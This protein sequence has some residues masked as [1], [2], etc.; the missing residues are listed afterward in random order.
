MSNSW[1]GLG[2]IQK[3]VPD[4]ENI[5]DHLFVYDNFPEMDFGGIERNT[6]F[7]I[8]NFNIEE[9]T[10]YAL[11]L[12][13]S[14]P[15]NIRIRFNYDSS[16]Y[17]GE[18]I[19]RLASLYKTICL[20]SFGADTPSKIKN[21]TAEFA[22][23]TENEKAQVSESFKSGGLTDRFSE[24]VAQYADKPAIEM[25]GKTLTFRQADELSNR[26]AWQLHT[27]GGLLAGERIAID[28]TPSIEAVISMI[29]IVKLGCC[30]I[31]FD[32]LMPEKRLENIIKD[33]SPAVILV[34][35]DKEP[36]FSIK[37]IK[38]SLERL[39]NISV[40]SDAIFKAERNSESIANIMFTSGTTSKPKGVIIKDGGILG[41]NVEP[42]YIDFEKTTCQFQDSSIAFDAAT[43]EIWS[44]MLNGRKLVVI[45]RNTLLSTEMFAKKISENKG[46][47]IF[48]TTTLFNNFVAQNAEIFKDASYVITG[49]EK[50]SE[51]HGKKFLD[52]C[53]DTKL[54]N[55]YGPTE[56]TTLTTCFEVIPESL[57]GT[58]PIGK[59]INTRGVIICDN[60]GD[61]LPDG[62][63]GEIIIYGQ[64]LALGYCGDKEITASKFV[65]L[66][67]GTTVYKSGDY[68]YRDNTGNIYFC[69]RFDNQLKLRGFR[70]STDEIEAALCDCSDIVSAAV[71]A[72]RNSLNGMF[73]AAYVVTKDGVKLKEC[74][75]RITEELGAI[76]PYYMIPSEFIEM[77]SLPV[78]SNGKLDKSMLKE[79][80]LHDE[81]FVYPETETEKKIY[82][83][84]RMVITDKKF[85]MNNSFIKMGGD[86]IK[87]MK[88]TALLKKNGFNIT[89]ADLYREQTP[90]RLAVYADSLSEGGIK[91]VND[92]IP[93]TENRYERFPLNNV[94]VAYL[95][96]RSKELV[97]GGYGTAFFSET[98]G[99]YDCKKFT[100]ALNTVIKRHDML[101]AVIY[102]NGTQQILHP[103]DVSYEIRETDIS[104]MDKAEQEKYL[105]LRYKELR[106]T[107]FEIGKWPMF[108]MRVFRTSENNVH[109]MYAFD[110]LIMDAFS[111][112]MLAGELESVYDGKSDDEELQL[113]FRDYVLESA[114]KTE[115][116][117]KDKKY[118]LDKV[119]N[120]PAA[121]SIKF[122]TLPENLRSP[123]FGRKH[124][125]FGREV[126]NRIK[127]LSAEMNITPAILLCGLYAYSLSL[128]SGQSKLAVNLTVF[129]R[130]QIHRQVDKILGDFTK[131]VLLDYDFADGND[132]KTILFQ[133]HSRLNDY[134]THLHFDGIDFMREL[135]R[136]QKQVNG[137]PLMPV[138][139]T[140]ALF[141]S[142]NVKLAYDF[143]KSASRTP[144]VYLDCQA[145]LRNEELHIV[146]DYPLG[147][148]ED[149]LLDNMF[150]CFT[151][152]ISDVEN[153]LE[154]RF[155]RNM[156]IENFY[157]RYNSTFWKHRE[158]SLQQLVKESLYS[159]E[160]KDKVWLLAENEQFTYEQTRKEAEKYA[161]HLQI[162]GVSCGDF[163]CI[164]GDR[165]P[166][167][168][169]MILGTVL[170]GA[171]Y[172]PVQP[173][174][175]E[176]RKKG[177]AS[178]SHCKC[179][180]KKSIN[181]TS[182][183][184]DYTETAKDAPAYVIYTSG[185]TGNPK[186]VLINQSAVT[187]TIL[188]INERYNI[189]AED[190]FAAV[191]SFSFDLSVY[192]IFGSLN[193]GA[194]ISLI[195]DMKNINAVVSQLSRDRVT[196]WNT[197]PALMELLTE[198][199]DRR[200][201]CGS[202][203]IRIALLSGDWIP[204]QLPN[205]VR[206]CFSGVKV[207][208]L[209]GATEASVWSIAYDIDEN[210]Q[211]D[212]HIPYG[213]PLR[214]QNM[215]VL[216]EA[217]EPLPAGIE[218]YIYRG[219][220]SCRRLSE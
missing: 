93:D 119:E 69:S 39:E 207:V 16:I 118:W 85:G 172:I 82:D 178:L 155:P 215:Y 206:K 63:I 144:Q 219:R 11:T 17:S 9:R 136:V 24:I 55:G 165:E 212:V 80:E 35:G 161:A 46:C 157:I 54:I 174:W 96:G 72:Y 95:S 83:I 124:M 15:D 89:V 77:D 114:K 44:A 88:L 26:L 8:I 202:I 111:V 163:V 56:S 90:A 211:Y 180:L 104:G 110:A 160:N 176:E 32:L 122:R 208:S 194:G 1:I 195:R 18:S 79:P 151:G 91:P 30:Y 112:V 170:C 188:D 203:P 94:Q 37:S 146:W 134:I 198:E 113:S 137:R 23:R 197:V 13:V 25:N 201:I 156:D 107:A 21:I 66:S 99:D 123:E 6:G 43:Y 53:P 171:A 191:S 71:K 143:D 205:A 192:D 92:I 140:S 97:L 187:N 139:F 214:N 162:S 135:S 145:M 129:S 132:F 120:F 196:V 185:S 182:G 81:D 150:E 199:V 164:E 75:N 33:A 70:I 62:S 217:L 115:E 73:L 14:K 159:V 4:C 10:E 49:G 210:I 22:E 153:I 98:S 59:P 78:K 193:A 216:S 42:D 40:P 31:P 168:L 68:G 190:I 142:N 149:E 20:N 52:A 152:F 167:T 61:I 175:P 5:I 57:E 41:M 60:N 116:F 100:E 50:F 154:N 106:N 12:E 3:S 148:Y 138:V 133:S 105:N 220:G 67:D 177:I 204:L 173:S 189:G 213:Y 169:F 58:I 183:K 103:E 186:G 200:D 34:F 127:T 101:R 65:T 64:G 209:G 102:N 48:L 121:P 51:Q 36:E 76:L 45:D 184:F 109:I 166:E 179:V 19:E 141:E 84:F 7:R 2:E 108:T 87:A 28:I 181:L 38:V 126:W 130:E 125:R 131:I 47:C 29:A 147:L 117:E 158:L 27:E 218:G 74:Q 128:Y 86:S